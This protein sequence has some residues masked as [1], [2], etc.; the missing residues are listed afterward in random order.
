MSRFIGQSVR[1]RVAPSS[2]ASSRST[3][4]PRNNRSATT[5]PRLS[6]GGFVVS[7]IDPEPTMA[8][9]A[10]SPAIMMRAALRSAA[11]SSSPPRR[12]AA[13][14]RHVGDRAGQ[15]RLCRRLDRRRHDADNN[16]SARAMGANDQPLRRRFRHELRF[17][18]LRHPL[19]DGAATLANGHV[20]F[21]WD[22][23][24]TIT[25]EDVYYRVYDI[26]AAAPPGDGSRGRTRSAARA[27]TIA[28]RLGGDDV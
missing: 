14:A 5:S 17:A 13:L 6:D 15:W 16:V 21:T 9:A 8:A 23:P 7:W 18:L 25:S 24:S 19:P 22:G 2:A 20:V 3:P 28:V 27:G 10:S 11:R 12:P 4:A 26:T 1:A